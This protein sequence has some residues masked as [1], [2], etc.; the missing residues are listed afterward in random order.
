MSGDDISHC[1]SLRGLKFHPAADPR[2]D[3]LIGEKCGK[4]EEYG[5]G[6]AV[7]GAEY[8]KRGLLGGGAD[9][10]GQCCDD[11]ATQTTTTP[12]RWQLAKAAPVPDGVGLSTPGIFLRVDTCSSAFGRALPAY[13]AS[14]VS[15]RSRARSP[16]ANRA[17]CS[18]RWCCCC[19]S[20]LPPLHRGLTQPL[21]TAAIFSFCAPPSSCVV[22]VPQ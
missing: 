14:A 10:S 20:S 6:Y 19:P 12:N 17:R 9:A 11:T 4:H 18:R 1:D 2:D 21:I 7:S 13:L 5:A 22:C 15:A 16:T 8:A 3:G